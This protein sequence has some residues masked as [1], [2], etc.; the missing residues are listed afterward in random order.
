MITRYKNCNSNEPPNSYVS[1]AHYSLAAQSALKK[2]EK[3]KL[4]FETKL[5]IVIR[6]YLRFEV[7]NR[8]HGYSSLHSGVR[9]TG[10]GNLITTR[11]QQFLRKR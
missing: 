4:G 9:H 1:I 10:T 6:A 5:L 2:K 11:P 7:H 3:S 8:A